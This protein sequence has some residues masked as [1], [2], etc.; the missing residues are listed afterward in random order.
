MRCR[1]IQ[2][3]AGG[4]QENAGEI[5]ENAGEYRRMQRSVGECRGVQ[6]ELGMECKGCR[7]SPSV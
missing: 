4:I 1:E 2:E 5:Q 6:G 7:G 3:N